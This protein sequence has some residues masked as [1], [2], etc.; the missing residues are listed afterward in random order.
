MK[1]PPPD[2]HRI[3]AENEQRRRAIGRIADEVSRKRAEDLGLSPDDN[4]NTIRQPA[5]RSAFLF[6]RRLL[7]W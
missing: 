1:T 3:L 6:L 7:P 2:F 4:R 5:R